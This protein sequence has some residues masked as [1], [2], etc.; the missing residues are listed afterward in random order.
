MN[1]AITLFG[2]PPPWS[3]WISKKDHLG[4]N[5]NS[6]SAYGKTSKTLCCGGSHVRWGQVGPEGRQWRWKQAHTGITTN[7]SWQWRC[8]GTWGRECFSSLACSNLA[9]CLVL[10]RLQSASVQGARGVLQL[11]LAPRSSWE[12]TLSSPYRDAISSDKVPPFVSGKQR[13]IQSI[14]QTGGKYWRWPQTCGSWWQWYIL[15]L[16]VTFH[17]GAW[18]DKPVV[19]ED[20]IW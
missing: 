1:F 17:L 15:R 2:S 16:S 6:K 13:S 4:Y 14:R 11:P 18:K 5:K 8:F 3:P 20:K 9:V 10:S 19:S 12:K 7:R